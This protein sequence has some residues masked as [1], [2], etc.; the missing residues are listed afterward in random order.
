M[1]AQ[2]LLDQ[3]EIDE[4]ERADINLTNILTKLKEDK[5]SK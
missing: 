1:N 5:K 4:Q 2:D 3:I